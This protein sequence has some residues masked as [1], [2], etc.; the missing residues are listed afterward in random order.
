VYNV[1]TGQPTS[2]LNLASIIAD[3][4]GTSLTLRHQPA[5]AGEIRHSLGQPALARQRLAT[6]AAT[7]LRDG[8]AETLAWIGAGRPGLI[9]QPGPFL[10]VSAERY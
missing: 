10:P 7:T 9:D 8:L 6:S 5:R 2:I 4:C 1:C 3:L